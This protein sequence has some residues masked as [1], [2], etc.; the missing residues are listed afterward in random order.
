[1]LGESAYSNASAMAF[2]APWALGG[3]ERVVFLCTTPGC[4]A[5]YRAAARNAARGPVTVRLNI[6]GTREHGIFEEVVRSMRRDWPW[7]VQGA[8]GWES[9]VPP[10]EEAP[11][12]GRSETWEAPSAAPAQETSVSFRDR[13]GRF[14]HG[15]SRE[16]PRRPRAMAERLLKAPRLAEPECGHVDVHGLEAAPPSEHG[17]ARLPGG[18]PDLAV[19]GLGPVEV[20]PLSDEI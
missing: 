11:L 19:E 18:A 10:V 13:L 2:G 6:A 4:E 1:M 15:P 14:G 12:P 3:G 8:P 16:P 9:Y 7:L 5:P 17:R 20:A